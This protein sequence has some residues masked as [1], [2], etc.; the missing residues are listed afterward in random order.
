MVAVPPPRHQHLEIGH[1]RG[2]K[3]AFNRNSRFNLSSITRGYSAAVIPL[4]QFQGEQRQSDTPQNLEG[5]VWARRESLRTRF[6]WT[7]WKD[8]CQKVNKW[9]ALSIPHL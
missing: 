4:L 6:G 3:Q 5:E 1:Q 2:A 8:D 9:N 7:V